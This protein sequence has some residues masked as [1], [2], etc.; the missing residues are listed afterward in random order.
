MRPALRIGVVLTTLIPHQYTHY[1][2]VLLFVVFGIKLL[3]DA[4]EMSA[5]GPSEELEEVE[6]E[7]SKE[8]KKKEAQV[9]SP[10]M[11]SLSSNK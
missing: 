5:E 7:L 3:K 6:A 9:T 11:D 4:Q 1:A 8:D 2:A 10:T